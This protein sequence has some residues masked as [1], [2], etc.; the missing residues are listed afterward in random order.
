MHHGGERRDG[1]NVARDFDGTFFGL[2]L[3]FLHALRVRT[4]FYVPDI[5]QNRARGWLEQARQLTVV[6]PS[7]GDG[8]LVNGAFGW[9]KMGRRFRWNIC[10]CAVQAHVTLALLFR[11][12]EGM[13]MQEGPDKL[14][15]DVLK[16]K[17]KMGVLIYGVV[18]TI[19]RGRSD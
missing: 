9:A 16:A 2:A 3:H 12:V 10:L 8:S 13:R 17:F 7:F 19:V 15:A 11:I 6:I 14:A 4:R 5:A 18:A 1:K